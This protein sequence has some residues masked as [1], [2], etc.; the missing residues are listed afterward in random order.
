[1]AMMAIVTVVSL[2]FSYVIWTRHRRPEMI[3]AEEESI[4]NM[5]DFS[6]DGLSPDGVLFGGMATPT[7]SFSTRASTSPDGWSA[8]KAELIQALKDAEEDKADAE[9]ELRTASKG[10]LDRS[11][12]GIR[13]ED[14]EMHSNWMIDQKDVTLGRQVGFGSF[15]VV[16][17]GKWAGVAVAVKV[18]HSESIAD[19]GRDNDS[20]DGDP[21]EEHAKIVKR[22]T[23]QKNTKFSE[24]KREMQLLATLNH[25]NIVRFFGC[26]VDPPHFY[27]VLLLP[28]PLPPPLLL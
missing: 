28:P 15:G 6:E 18:L 2:A 9:K 19:H 14:L 5:R 25:P 23:G 24:L 26:V 1:M 20:P 17:E 10:A 27:L 3:V 13:G 11:G 16:Y 7:Q 4:T 21:D 8:E 12:N 22:K